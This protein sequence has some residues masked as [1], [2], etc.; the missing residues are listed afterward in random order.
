MKGAIRRNAILVPQRAVQQGAKGHFMWVV[1]KEGKAEFR[2]V[3]VGDWYGNDVFIDAGLHDGDQIVVDG[4]LSVRQGE[5][6]KI[7]PAAA[8]QPGEP[9]A[10][11]A[12][13][14]DTAPAAA[15]PAIPA[16]PAAAPSKPA[17]KPVQSGAPARP[18]VPAP[19][20]TT[21][22]GQQGR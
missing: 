13:K 22:S 12:V 14:I 7:K 8:S 20:G 4:V 18:A 5:S 21:G 11:P 3:T 17:V 9:G 2:P 16:G 1:N 15:S 6:V 10:K 19:P